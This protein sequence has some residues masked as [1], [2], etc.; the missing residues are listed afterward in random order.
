MLTKCFQESN[1]CTRPWIFP[2]VITRSG[3]AQV[4][5]AGLKASK[6]PLPARIFAAVDVYDALTSEQPYRKAWSEED[7]LNLIR[8]ESGKH[9]D[10]EVVEVFLEEIG[11]RC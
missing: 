8:E 2:T 1:I 6:Y 10:P 3:T 11:K 7:A 5:P 4:I 9:F